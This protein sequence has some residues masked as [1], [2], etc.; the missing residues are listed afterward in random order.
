MCCTVTSSM[1]ISY[2]FIFCLCA[3]IKVKIQAMYINNDVA[4]WKKIRLG[5]TKNERK[6]EEKRKTEAKRKREK[7]GKKKKKGR[8][9]NAEF[10]LRAKGGYS[11]TNNN[12]SKA[13]ATRIIESKVDSSTICKR[14]LCI[15]LGRQKNDCEESGTVPLSGS[16]ETWFWE[17][18]CVAAWTQV[19]ST[20]STF[21]QIWICMAI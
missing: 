14:L 7:G 20:S 17:K 9:K 5:V 21:I 3:Y 15:P 2:L 1:D 12:Q 10:F 18:Q 13:I 8:E 6:R 11:N 19:A 4:G 16:L